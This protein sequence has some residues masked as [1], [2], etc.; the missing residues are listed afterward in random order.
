[1]MY[2][3][4]AVSRDTTKAQMTNSIDNVIKSLQTEGHAIQNIESHGFKIDLLPLWM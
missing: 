2:I 1:M 4:L 3:N